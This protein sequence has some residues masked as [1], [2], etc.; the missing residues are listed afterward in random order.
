MGRRGEDSHGEHRREKTGNA[1]IPIRHRS[2]ELGGRTAG[3]LALGG[4]GA[5]IARRAAAFGM[6]VI[7]VDP[8]PPSVPKEVEACWGTERLRDMLGQSDVVFVSAPLT[9]ETRSLFNA[10]TF[11]AMKPDSVL[12]NVSRGEIVDE[13]ALLDAL[14]SGHLRAAGLDVTPREALPPDSPLW[15]HP[16][17]V[18]TP[19][20]PG[21]S[22]FRADRIVAP[23]AGAGRG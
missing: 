16:H 23:K 7:A 20:A 8:E 9:A 15:D 21:P 3:L 22:P 2:W 12:I 18:V 13:A 1:R 19:H 14:E 11:A 17:V 4:T 6:R 5:E 10:E